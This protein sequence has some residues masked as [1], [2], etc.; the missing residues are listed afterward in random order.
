M[1]FRSRMERD[2]VERSRTFASI[3]DQYLT[4]VKPMHD[5]FVEPSKQYADV[6][7][8]MRKQNPIALDLIISKLEADLM[9]VTAH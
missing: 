3:K 4:T 7:V 8:P 1:L 5:A 2:M 9:K 6:I